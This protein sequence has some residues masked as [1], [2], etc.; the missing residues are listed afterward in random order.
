MKT[1]VQPSVAFQPA[2]FGQRKGVPAPHP[3]AMPVTVAGWP[4]ASA[5]FPI[6]APHLPDG[7]QSPVLFGGK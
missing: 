2:P 7:S 5:G 3:L 4:A 1:T 6:G